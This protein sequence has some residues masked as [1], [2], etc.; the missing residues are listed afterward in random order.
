MKRIFFLIFLMSFYSCK[1]EEKGVEPEFKDFG[2]EVYQQV[3]IDFYNFKHQIDSDY[4]F[5]ITITNIKVIEHKN[6]FEVKRDKYA[7]PEKING[8]SV[9]IEFEIK[10]PYDRVMRIPFPWYYEIG[11]ENYEGLDRNFVGIKEDFYM[12]NECEVENSEGVPLSSFS[13]E[14]LIENSKETVV[15]FKPNESK[16]IVV[17]FTKPFPSYIKQVLFVGFDKYIKN[18]I[19]DISYMSEEQKNSYFEDKSLNYGLVI[20]LESKKIIN[21]VGLPFR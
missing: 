15:E 17:K 2:K 6:V 7:R 10:N 19:E 18:E 8:T 16:S 4:S 3:E 13:K 11:T 5:D 12:T 20:D 1:N 14:E 21:I 9:T